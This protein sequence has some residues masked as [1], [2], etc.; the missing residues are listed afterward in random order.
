MSPLLR[1]EIRL[2]LPYWGIAMLLA[3]LPPLAFARDPHDPLNASLFWAFGFG[4]VLLGLAPF[5]YEFSAGTFSSLMVQPMERRRI[6]RQKILVTG[7]GALLVLMA[8][9]LMLYWRMDLHLRDW[10]QE[11]LTKFRGPSPVTRD[12]LLRGQQE[13]FWFD[14]WH[15]SRAVT[16]LLFV[17]ITGGFW[18]TLLFRQT[19]AALWFVIL[20]P[21]VLSAALEPVSHF[22]PPDKMQ[23]AQQI[24]IT[25]T[26]LTYSLYS[27]AG[28]FWARRM[29]A[30]AQDSQWLGETVAL[31]NLKSTKVHDDSAAPRHKAAVRA[32]IRKEFQSHQI[33]L[34]IAFALLVLHICALIFRRVY[35]L[36][37]NS[38]FRFVVEAVPFLWLLVPWLIGCVTIAEERKLGVMESQLCLPITRRT[39]FA[40]KLVI[41][42][43]LGVVLGGIMPCLIEG[44]GSWAGLPSEIV[45]SLSASDSSTYFATALELILAAG[46]ISLV[47]VFASSLTR[48]T[49]HALGAAV[50][51]G[52]AWIILFQ[53]VVNQTNQYGYSLWKGPLIFIIGIPVS[54]IA[55]IALSF[56][57]YKLLHAGRN[58]WLRN[59]LALSIVLIAT[60]FATAVIYQRP[61]ELAISVE[62]RHGSRSLSGPVQPT[63]CT[64]QGKIF[65]LLP[66]GRLWTATGYERTELDVNSQTWNP[67]T[68]KFEK[69][70]VQV[71]L[72]TGGTFITGSNWTV[73]SATDYEDNV[74]GLRSDGTLWDLSPQ[75]ETNALWMTFWL[76]RVP[77][78]RRVGSDSDWKTVVAGQNYF[79]AIKTNGTLWGWGENQDR[80]LSPDSNGYFEQPVQIGTNSDWSKFF[81]EG[82]GVLV[83]KTNGDLWSWQENRGR[84]FFG[85]VGW[86]AADW[87]SIGGSSFGE[88]INLIVR[89]DGTLWANGPRLAGQY[90]GFKIYRQQ[91]RL[92]TDTDWLQISGEWPNLYAL[93][94]D[95]R[96]LK[97]GTEPFSSFLG[98]PSKY[99]D[100]LAVDG[101]ETETVALAAD[102]TICEWVDL[103]GWGSDGSPLAPSRRPLWS[104]NVLAN[105]KN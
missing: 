43:F 81:P 37:R 39:Q 93:K 91:G 71:E 87:L 33:S 104:L 96:L 86:N 18:A 2:L 55:T 95:G 102:G 50:V 74:A 88:F 34:L 72:P 76:S 24:S 45:K 14:F 56:S 15:T 61:W 38:E 99:S 85:R 27:I 94:K 66:D 17:A 7:L 40:V 100:W 8:F 60:G 5:G 79:Y 73:L 3:V 46:L 63:I 44:I 25:L 6:W 12:D 105:P 92:G 32:L 16:L 65:A 29:F 36:P 49:L 1:K 52:I 58:V 20:I 103:R 67:N 31:L 84:A 89:Q 90:F 23:V 59:L 75:K 4:M 51:F 57:N 41:A 54:M 83:M 47:S 101:G 19:G 30:T 70:K 11:L 9:E 42:L 97:D 21:G 22:F 53:I 82:Q 10:S 69:V 64:P 80:R 13:L 28:F 68:Q 35:V 62:P 48:N 78:P 98:R 77:E 26:T